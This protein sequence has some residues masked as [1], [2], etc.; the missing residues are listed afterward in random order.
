MFCMIHCGN[1]RR[2]VQPVVL[3]CFHDCERV[4][5]VDSTY[6]LGLL[7]EEVLPGIGVDAIVPLIIFGVIVVIGAIIGTAQ[8]AS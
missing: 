6:Q 1:E 5:L 8:P 7:E 3:R 4:V 2:R